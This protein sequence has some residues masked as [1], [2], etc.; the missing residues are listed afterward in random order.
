MSQSTIIAGVLL[1]AFIV[2]ITMKGQLPQYLNVIGLSPSSSSNTSGA[3]SGFGTAGAGLL[4]GL[5][6]LQATSG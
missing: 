1:F 4:S 6:S 3:S 2:F 5:P